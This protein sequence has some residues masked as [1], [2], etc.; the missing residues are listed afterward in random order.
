MQDRAWQ[1]D[2]IELDLELNN[3]EFW[4]LII[5]FYLIDQ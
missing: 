2:L 5:R 3:N 4:A 1:M